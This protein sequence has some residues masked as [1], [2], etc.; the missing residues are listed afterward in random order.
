MASE[1]LAPGTALRRWRE[2]VAAADAA[3]ALVVGVAA[4]FTSQSLEPHLGVAL[5]DRA[6][7]PQLRLADFNLIH[8]SCLDPF[9]TFGD[10]VR[11][12]LVLWRLEDVFERDVVAVFEGDTGAARRLIDGVAELAG[13][14][15]QCARERHLP[16]VFGVPPVPRG[17][18]LDLADPATSLVAARLQQHAADVMLDVV[19]GV[20]GIRLLDH[21]QIVEHVGG[22]AAHDPRGQLLYRQPYRSALLAELAAQAAELLASF[23][24][25][26]PKVVVVD[27]D[28]TLW[29]GIVGEEGAAG[30]DIGS[31]FPGSAY[32]Q[33]QLVLRRLSQ[34]G[35]LIAV[36]SKNNA[37]DVDEVFDTRTEM[38]LRRGDIAAWRVNWASKSDNIE[39]IAEELNVGLDSVVFVDD[40]PFEVSEVAN[41]LP[42]VR[43]LAVPDEPAELPDLLA[44]SGLFRALAVTAEDRRRTLMIR[45][46]QQRS[47]ARQQVS[48]VE[49]LTTLGLV[50]RFFTVDETHVARVAQL[51]NKTNQ[52][53]LTTQRHTE[54]EVAALIASPH[55]RLFAVEVED[56]FGDYGL[57]GVTHVA[58]G[59]PGSWRIENLLMS[60]RVLGRGVES[61]MLGAV[62][63]KADAA[64]ATE[65]V[66]CFVPTAKNAQVERFYVDHGFEP[67]G[68]GSFVCSPA[69]VARVP[70]HTTLVV[71]A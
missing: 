62:A 71:D 10:D 2:Y 5:I 19:D 47:A 64:G 38:A 45:D 9:G 41:A 48:P 17:L 44:A 27:C 52:F 34:L 26:P 65:L 23:E 43:C 35:V 21:R 12:L 60:C 15:V 3:D 13:L 33:F 22:E 40:S 24:R 32:R 31:T 53:N 63:G 70:V 55:D 67:L 51:V 1:T 49:F 57:V 7:A 11:R 59:S 28:N 58:T 29:G 68:D 20:D 50:V 30:V 39:A 66:G 37:A 4:S 36:C 25:V 46:E 16:I 8:Q 6:L 18:G 42:A 14:V 69:R 54:S 56:R 61:A